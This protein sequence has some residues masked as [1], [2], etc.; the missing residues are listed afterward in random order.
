MLT[1]FRRIR[2]SLLASNQARK[3]ILYALG[4][5]LLVMVGI[6]LALS[7]NNWKEF[8]IDRIKEEKLLNELMENLEFNVNN[9]N[10]IIFNFKSDDRSSDLI[11]SVLK[12]GRGYHD[13]LDYYFARSLNAE[14]LY[15]LSFVGY[16]SVRNT[17]FDIIINDQLKEEII[18]L[19]ELTYSTM[20]LRQENL[21]VLWEFIRKRFMNSPDDWSLKP[22]DFEELL[23]DREYI[24]C[25]NNMKSNRL[26]IRE[27]YEE[28]FE[29]TNRVLKLIKDEL[30]EEQ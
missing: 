27:S 2:K 23:E 3:Y 16:E 8:R 5:V 14:P 9:L 10:R 20:Q 1:F 22:F 15:P 4:E 13:S 7:I 21:P 18:N 24:S 28:S 11:I 19:F 12:E 6:L 17:G 26:W 30:G 29:E 25:V